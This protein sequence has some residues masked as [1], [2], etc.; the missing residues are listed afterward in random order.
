M[1]VLQCRGLHDLSIIMQGRS[2]SAGSSVCTSIGCYLNLKHMDKNTLVM[3]F[4]TNLW[5]K[6]WK[7]L[8]K[9]N[10]PRWFALVSRIIKAQIV[11]P[12]Q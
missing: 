11:S 4:P 7:S 1:C 5:E 9:K 8:T 10:L 2:G 12:F 3:V 6:K